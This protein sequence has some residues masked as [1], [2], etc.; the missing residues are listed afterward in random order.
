MLTGFSHID[1]IDLDT[2]DVS[3]LNRQFLFQKKHF[4]RS[5]AQV[6]KG[7]VL[8]FYPKANIAAYHDSIMNP[9]YNVEI[10]QQFILDYNLL[11]NILH[12][13]DLGKDVKFKV[14]GD[15]PDKVGPKQAKDATKSITNGSNDGAQP[16]TFTAQEQ[17]DV[18]I[19]DSDKED[20]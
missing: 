15:A 6:A 10:F 4:G 2:I 18:L 14:V 12:S 7:S 11:I 16:S 5:K 3:N 1:L 9:D 19:V 8:Q 20:P 17:D 13:E